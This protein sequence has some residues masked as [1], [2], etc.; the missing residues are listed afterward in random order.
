M[1]FANAVFCLLLPLTLLVSASSRADS[2]YF[3][4]G[5]YLA[6]LNLAIGSEDDLTPAGFIGYQFLDSNFLMLSAEVGY[7]NLGSV[8]SE[9]A[10]VRYSVDASALSLAGVAYLPLGSFFEVY[11]KAGMARIELESRVAGQLVNGDATEPFAGV[12]VAWDFFDTV[13][14]YAEYLRFDNAVDSQ[15]LGIG[16][17]FD[18]F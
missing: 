7:Y 12:G 6:D 3:G 4:A 2:L 8:S 15:L 14:I 9:I 10:D 5:A 18:F 1:P 13:D 11:A 16:I 17:R